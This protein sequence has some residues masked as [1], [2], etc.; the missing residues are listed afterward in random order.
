MASANSTPSNLLAL[1][2]NQTTI[3]ATPANP[4]RVNALSAKRVFQAYGSTTVG[5]GASVIEIYG[6]LY[7]TAGPWVL[8]GTIS[9]TLGTA[10]VADGFASD[11]PWPF[12]A[13]KVVSISGT[14]AAVTVGLG[15]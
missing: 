12:I 15:A 3:D 13:V 8:L 6:S 10:V 11:A 4:A 2:S 14:G 5:T 7:G 1:I 9:L